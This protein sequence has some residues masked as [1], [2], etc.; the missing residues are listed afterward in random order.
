MTPAAP[1]GVRSLGWRTVAPF[2]RH[3]HRAWR[4]LVAIRAPLGIGPPVRTLQGH[5]EIRTQLRY[6][7]RTLIATTD[8]TTGK[9]DPAPASLHYGDPV[10]WAAITAVGTVL[11][12]LALP[13]AFIQ[14][15]ALRQDRLREQVS[16]IG[17]WTEAE[18]PGDAEWRVSLLIRNASELPVEVHVTELAIDWLGYQT[19]LASADGEPP[20]LYSNKRIGPTRLDYFFPGTIGPGFF[21]GTI[22]P[23]RTWVEYR[24]YSP[25]GKFD[26]PP[27]PR[28]SIIQVA[29]TDVAGRQWELRPH[30]GG[31]ARRVRW[32]REW[33]WRHRRLPP[34]GPGRK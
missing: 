10:P 21:P 34:P 30:R 18:D 6:P 9:A 3:D 14:L 31:R 17:V 7:G 33:P 11:A 15:G 29:I 26:A 16:K 12:G 32:R 25:V 27:Q 2:E 28:I 13:L 19:V 1:L 24:D 22:G 4:P 20:Q 23:G 8:A 5:G